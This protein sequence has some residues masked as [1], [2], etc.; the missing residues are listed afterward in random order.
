MVRT[1]FEYQLKV[2]QAV[3]QTD[4]WGGGE[5]KSSPSGLGSRRQPERKK[6]AGGKRL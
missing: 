5:L 4:Q 3:S 1:L 6:G 2:G